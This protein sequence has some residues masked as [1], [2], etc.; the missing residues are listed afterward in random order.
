MPF[1]QYAN[2]ALVTT[3]NYRTFTQ[4]THVTA[5]AVAIAANPG[6]VIINQVASGDAST[7]TVTLP[8]VAQGG[9]VEV[10]VVGVVG[11]ASNSVV[12]IP[13]VVDT[14]AGCKIDQQ[15]NSLALIQPNS[16]VVLASDGTNWWLISSKHNTQDTW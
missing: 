1:P 6:D 9:P 16:N 3:A 10:K 5:G 12:I 2:A 14:V 15:W 4:G 13:Q 8:P 11:Q 7:Y